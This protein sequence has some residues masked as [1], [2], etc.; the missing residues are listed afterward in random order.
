MC[1]Q[2]AGNTTGYLPPAPSFLPPARCCSVRVG[3]GE[4][5]GNL[6]IA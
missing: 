6:E 1:G 2:A 5:E 4:E 3:C